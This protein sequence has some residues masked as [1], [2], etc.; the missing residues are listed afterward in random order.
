MDLEPDEAGAVM[1]ILHETGNDMH[2]ADVLLT[3]TIMMAE[4][5]G[6]DIHDLRAERLAAVHAESTKVLQGGQRKK[7]VGRWSESED[8]LPEVGSLPLSAAASSLLWVLAGSV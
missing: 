4:G 5:I 3:K 1:E 2:R 8:G 6:R 7:A